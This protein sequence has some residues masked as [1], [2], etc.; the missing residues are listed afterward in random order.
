MPVATTSGRS[1]A[2]CPHLPRAE[3][4]CRVRLRRGCRCRR[5]RSRCP[6]R[7]ELSDLEARNRAQ[8]IAR[9]RS[10]ALRVRQMTGIVVRR[11]WPGSDAARARGSPI[12]TSTSETSRTRD[13]KA[14]AR[15]DHAGS[16]ASSSPYS[17]IDDPQPAALT[18][19][20]STPACRRRRSAVARRRAPRRSVRRG[21]PARRS[22]LDRPVRS[23]SHPSAASTLIVAPLT[24]GNTRRCTQPVSRPTFSRCA[25]DGG[26][27]LG[28]AAARAT[29]TTPA[30]R[31][32]ISARRRG[33]SRLTIRVR[34]ERLHRLAEKHQRRE[35][36]A[37][38]SRIGQRR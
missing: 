6:V 20:R 30:A 29:P 15:A 31:A 38:T 21:A 36:D 28:S 4:A 37:Q 5:C 11:P 1:A 14:W 23:P 16:S 25:P 18:T 24:C 34:L 13:E 22:T 33:G 10:D 9:L 7:P 19:I 35:H 12:S 3:L 8:Q 32:Q 2:M 17:F 27:V 26:G